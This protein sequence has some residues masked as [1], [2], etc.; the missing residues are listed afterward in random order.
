MIVSHSL[1]FIFVHP[2]KTG[3]TSVS[4]ALDPHLAWD[5]IVIGGSP[6]GQAIE[7]TYGERFGMRK[8]S[9]VAEIER[10]VGRR[11][12]RRYF[13]FATVRH[14][15][16]RMC[17][18]YNFIA[19]RLDKFSEQSGVARADILRHIE[20]HPNAVKNAPQLG[21]HASQ[22]LLSTSGFSEFIR[23]A[24]KPMG[25]GLMSQ[26]DHLKSGTDGQIHCTA[27][28]LEDSVTWVPELA[29]RLGVPLALEQRNRSTASVTPES[30]SREDL[31]FIESKYA[32][33]YAAFGY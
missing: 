26:F 24:I 22:V 12:L 20:R 19:T 16:D 6:R 8:H 28:R 33:D 30:V 23:S 2:L 31:S 5:D 25:N 17:S 7:A 27:Y 15:V 14:P 10:V 18:F 3:G 32:T 9:P 4:M 21:W 1:K 29:E 13:V 11:L